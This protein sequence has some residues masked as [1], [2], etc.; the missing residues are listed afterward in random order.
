MAGWVRVV[1]GSER[2][3]GADLLCWQPPWLHMGG[4]SSGIRRVV[5]LAIQNADFEQLSALLVSKLI[6]NEM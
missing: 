3:G 4:I 5:L 6:I 2:D 1:R